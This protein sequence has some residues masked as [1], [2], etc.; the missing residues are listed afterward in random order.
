MENKEDSGKAEKLFKTFGKKVDQFMVELNEAGD[1]LSKEFEGR[2][3]ELKDSAEKLQK[4]AKN[5]ERW[6]EVEQS[7]KKAGE[8]LNRAVKAAFKKR[9]EKKS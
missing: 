8:E 4:E 3:E 1:R 5:K 7:L 6:K 2:Y 9:D